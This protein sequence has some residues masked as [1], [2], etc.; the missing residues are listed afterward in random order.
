MLISLLSSVGIAGLLFPPRCEL[1]LLVK[2]TTSS[3]SNL[4]RTNKNIYKTGNYMSSKYWI[5]VFIEHK[6]HVFSLKVIGGCHLVN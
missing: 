1:D 6:N 2:D 3:S 4:K 5:L